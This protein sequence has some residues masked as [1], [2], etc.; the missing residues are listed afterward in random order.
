MFSFTLH[1]A[2]VRVAVAA[3]VSYAMEDLTKAFHKTH[4]DI[5]IEVILGS[6]GKLT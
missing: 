4:P 6:S 2:Q 5:K 3:N 1:A